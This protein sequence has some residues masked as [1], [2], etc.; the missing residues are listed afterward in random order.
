TNRCSQRITIPIRLNRKAELDYSWNNAEFDTL[1][2]GCRERPYIDT[3]ITITNRSAELGQPRAVDVLSVLNGLPQVFTILSDPTPVTLQPGEFTKV[4]I[5]FSSRDS[6]ATYYDTLLIVSS[7]RCNS[8]GA[9]PLTGI[10]KEV[11]SIRTTDGAK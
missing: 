6:S 11:L 5:R 1:Y 4:R 2:A 10:V 7:D 3:T 8:I 9:V